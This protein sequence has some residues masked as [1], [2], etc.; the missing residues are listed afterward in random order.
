MTRC[1]DCGSPIG[2]KPHEY[3]RQCI[4]AL[5]GRLEALE[6][7]HRYDRPHCVDCGYFG[8]RESSLSDCPSG[9]GPLAPGNAA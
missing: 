9:H 4:I 7:I 2:D 3:Q 5:R 6:R 8:D 1:L